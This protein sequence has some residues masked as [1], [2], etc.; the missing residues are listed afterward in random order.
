MPQHPTPGGRHELGQNFL[1]HLPTVERIVALVRE[2]RGPIL[3]SVPATEPSPVRWR[4][5]TE[6]S[7]RST[8]TP[9]R[10]P[11]CALACPACA[12]ITPMC[13]RSRSTLR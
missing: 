2:T 13:S 6:S 10:S 11:A 1:V 8:S 9:V 7:A 4:T 5:S 12:S 3:E